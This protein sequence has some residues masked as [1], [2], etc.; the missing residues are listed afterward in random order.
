MNKSIVWAIALVFVTIGA[1]MAASMTAVWLT[2][3][4]RVVGLATLPTAIAAALL[5]LYFDWRARLQR[6]ILADRNERHN[7]IGAA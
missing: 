2:D 3:E 6:S 4:I 5:V 7:W 1:V